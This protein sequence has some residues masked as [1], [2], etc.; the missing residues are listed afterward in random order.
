MQSTNVYL[1]KKL[2]AQWAEPVSLTFHSGLMKL[3]TESS[4]GAS[5]QISIN[6]AKQKDAE[7]EV[8]FDCLLL[9]LQ[10]LMFHGSWIY[11]Y[12]CNQCLSL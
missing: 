6:L 2:E 4:M 3:N 12:I 10:W 8:M 7:E 9:S 11:N 5:Y 1:K